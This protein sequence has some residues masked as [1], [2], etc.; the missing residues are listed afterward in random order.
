MDKRFMLIYY[1]MDDS[2][3]C[4]TFDTESELREFAEYYSSDDIIDAFEVGYIKP[5]ELF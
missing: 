5:I 3:V 2:Q 4:E 1:N